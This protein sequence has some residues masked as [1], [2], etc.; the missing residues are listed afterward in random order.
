MLYFIQWRIVF[1]GGLRIL[2]LNNLFD[3]SS[4][5]D[6]SSFKSL[7]QIFVF[8]CR[9]WIRKIFVRDIKS[10]SSFTL[11]ACLCQSCHESMK[12]WYELLSYSFRPWAP[13]ILIVKEI[14]V[15]FIK[16]IIQRVP[17]NNSN[18]YAL[19]YVFHWDISN[20]ILLQEINNLKVFLL[21]LW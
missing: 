12:T 4:P 20:D 21:F 3:L 9:F 8:S 7:E 5:V 6:D 1:I 15:H 18:S 2:V 14:R 10:C 16:K 19:I 11:V 17:I 13:S